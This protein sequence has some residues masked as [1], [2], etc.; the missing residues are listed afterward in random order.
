M[1]NTIIEMEDG[2]AKVGPIRSHIE[3]DGLFLR[4][5]NEGGPLSE[6]PARPSDEAVLAGFGKKQQLK[7]TG[8]GRKRSSVADQNFSV[9]SNHSRLWA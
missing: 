1:S 9:V 3:K 7:V 4:K 8:V 6:G 2:N 5:T